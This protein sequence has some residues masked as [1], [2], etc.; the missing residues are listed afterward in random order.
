MV[1][2]LALCHKTQVTV[3]D[4]NRRL[5][6][7]PFAYVAECLTTDG[8][9]LCSFRGC[10]AIRPVFSKLFDERSSDFSRLAGVGLSEIEQNG[11]GEQCPR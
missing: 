10:P 5:F 11:S 2:S 8:C 3:D 6:D 7:L 9:L 4:R 1:G